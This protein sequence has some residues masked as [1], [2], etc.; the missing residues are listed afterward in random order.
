MLVNGEHRGEFAVLLLLSRGLDE[1]PGI[2]NFIPCC[3]RS[4]VEDDVPYG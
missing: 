1:R 4:V 3:T 2:T